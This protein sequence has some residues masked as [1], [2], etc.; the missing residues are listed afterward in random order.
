MLGTNSRNLITS[1]PSWVN[2]RKV[3]IALRAATL[4]R[5][6][7]S[8]CKHLSR[9]A[10]RSAKYGREAFSIVSVKELKR[11]NAT[12]RWSSCSLWLHRKRKRSKSGHSPEGTA[13]FATI[14]TTVLNCNGV[15]EGLLDK[16]F[17]LWES[18]AQ[19]LVI[20]L[21]RRT[22]ASWRTS[23]VL[24]VCMCWKRARTSHVQ[25]KPLNLNSL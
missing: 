9:R 10:C 20:F 23:G 3:S 4:T 12:S 16:L 1:S 18:L 24:A 22:A 21:R 14:L 17:E 8:S 15:D 13:Y 19:W 25:M 11:I 7:V 6:L 5:L 2:S